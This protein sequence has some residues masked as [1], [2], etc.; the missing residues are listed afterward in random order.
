MKKSRKIVVYVLAGIISFLIIPE[1]VLR[2][3][4]SDILLRISDF[5]SLGGLFSPF[6]S[7]IIFLGVSSISIGILTVY[8]VSKIYRVLTPAKDK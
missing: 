1:I 6:L 7:S 2:K 3:V 4:P 8:V 5:T